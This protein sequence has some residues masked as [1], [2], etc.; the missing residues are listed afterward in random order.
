MWIGQSYWGV[1][2]WETSGTGNGGVCFGVSPTGSS[3]IHHIILANNVANGCADGFSVSSAS[4]K[5]GVDYVSIVGNIAWNAARS[6][7]LC[8]SGVTVY[9]PI[10][11]DSNAGTHIFIAGNFSFDNTSPT[12]CNGG[13]STYD[14]NGIVLDDIGNVQSGGAAY[15][16]QIVVENNIAVWNGGYGFGNTG[17]GTPSAA[18]F[19]LYNTSAHNLTATNSNTTTC[20]DIATLS[21]SFTTIS[22]N[23]IETG[24]SLGCQ[25]MSQDAYAVAVN[26]ADSTDTV[27]ANWLYS[28]AG[29]NTKA[30]SSSGFTFGANITGTDPVLAN[31]EDPGPPNCA[32][33]ASTVDCMSTVIANY[34]PT[35]SAAKAFGYQMPTMSLVNDPGFPQWL[36]KADLPSG[37]VTMGCLNDQ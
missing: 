18:I 34:K 15:T 1:Q 5:V 20:G 7:V 12:N 25:G 9:E 24:A 22:N 29:N 32:G 10:N 16:Q 13:R 27:A 21:S 23:L 37:L 35:N 8:N 3:A 4:A 19:Y 17:N 36:C 31:P 6:T 11:W 14:G 33:K 30:I 26:A 2:G 28:Q